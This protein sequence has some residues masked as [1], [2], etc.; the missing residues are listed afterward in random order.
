MGRV[1]LYIGRFFALLTAP[2]VIAFLMLSVATAAFLPAITDPDN[3]KDGLA[4]QRIYEDIVPV[5]LPAAVEL[6]SGAPADFEEQM[7][8]RLADIRDSLSDDDW[9]AVANEIVPPEWIQAQVESAIDALYAY[10]DGAPRIEYQLETVPLSERL[11]G[12]AAERAITRILALARPCTPA[13]MRL[14]RA[15]ETPENIPI[16]S[17]S[18]DESAEQLRAYLTTAFAQLGQTIEGEQLTRA[19]FRL[20]TL[21]ERLQTGAVSGIVSEEAPISALIGMRVAY[22]TYEIYRSIAFLLVGVSFGAIVFFAVRSFKGLARWAGWLSIAGGAMLV[23][24]L[25]TI[26][27]GLIEVPAI[28]VTSELEDIPPELLEIQARITNGIL[29]A[30]FQDFSRP[31]LGAAFGLIAGGFALL[32][33]SIFLPGPQ[34]IVHIDGATAEPAPSP[35]GRRVVEEQ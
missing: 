20:F 35:S 4:A 10:F 11:T 23:F 1:L 29:V 21:A 6:A 33:A 27:I 5:A 9:R 17:P 24:T 25:L 15:P 31:A 26:S 32:V 13:E 28:E 14:L 12:A 3:I 8:L 7:P 34:Q 2:L 16:C 18:D 22:E 19:D 30:A